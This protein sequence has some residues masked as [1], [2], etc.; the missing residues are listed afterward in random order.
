MLLNIEVKSPDS[1]E[2]ASKYNHDLA[3]EKVIELVTKYEAGPK[4]I[5]SSFKPRMLQS[6][7]KASTP[8]PNRTFLIMRSLLDSQVDPKNYV[9]P[10]HMEGINISYKNL[11]RERVAKVHGAHKL[12]GVWISETGAKEDRLMWDKVFSIE[13]G[14]VNL[15]FSDRPIE[16]IKARNVLQA[17]KQ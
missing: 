1:E 5:I 4:T 9:T 7:I 12:V 14:A 16:A 11:N 3:A 2:Y 6:I 15:F 13:D 17:K 10:D 8:R